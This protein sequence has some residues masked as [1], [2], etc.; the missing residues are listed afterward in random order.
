VNQE[1][2]W[3]DDEQAKLLELWALDLSTAEIGRQMGRGKN[4]IV[5]K[6]HRLGLARPSPIIRD[7]QRAAP[8]PARRVTGPT[9]PPIAAVAPPPALV[10]EAVADAF[11]RAVDRLGDALERT[12]REATQI[13]AKCE[14]GIPGA[15]PA[16]PTPRTRQPRECCWPIGEPGTKSFRYC[17]AEFS[18]P[19][20]SYCAEHHAIAWVQPK[21]KPATPT[22]N[23]YV[24]PKWGSL[25]LR[26]FRN[27]AGE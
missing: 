9:L 4:S 27:V 13:V 25:G 22:A 21:Q 20:R 3:S 6:A 18:E 5:G 15:V 1:N 8:R 12:M 16:A 17:D 11:E 2:P 24:P 23:S 26:S 19:G 7:G 14:W 10:A